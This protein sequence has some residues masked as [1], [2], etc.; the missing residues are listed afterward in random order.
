[1]RRLIYLILGLS[2]FWFIFSRLT[3]IELFFEILAGGKWQWVLIALASQMLFFA[4][5]SNLYKSALSVAGIEN[6]FR[7]IVPMVMGSAFINVLAPT[8][9]TAGVALFISQ[10]KRSKRSVGKTIVGIILA[11][12]INY[13]VFLVILS[14]AYYYLFTIGKV[15]RYEFIALFLFILLIAFLSLI[16]IL[17][18]YYSNILIKIL[19]WLQKVI[20][21]ISVRFRYKPLADNWADV[22]GQEFIIGSNAVDLRSSHM[23]SA[24]ISGILLHTVNIISL[25]VIFLAFYQ[26]VSLGLVVI[27]YATIILFWV[28]APTPQGIGVVEG[29]G[30]LVLTSLGIPGAVSA[31]VIL[32]FRGLNLWLPAVIGLILLHR[33]SIGQKE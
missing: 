20:N 3:E 7:H 1:M 12:I 6:R 10:A 18:R 28:L 33:L 29:V 23:V 13:S 14:V 2:F 26:N 21:R 15:A 16:I 32:I 27:G 5:S 4:I 31:A 17:A 19:F 8:A 11:W 30:A 9:G 24:V 25:Y 22:H